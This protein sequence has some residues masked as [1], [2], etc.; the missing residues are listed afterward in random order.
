MGD[1]QDLER[2][3]AEVEKLRAAKRARDEAKRLEAEVQ[4]VQARQAA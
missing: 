4:R 3:E 1:D 2:L